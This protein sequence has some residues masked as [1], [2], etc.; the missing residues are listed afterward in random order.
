MHISTAC[1]PA[2]LGQKIVVIVGS[3][4]IGLETP[5]RARSEGADLILT[6]RDP[7]RLERAASE[8]GALRTAA[9]DANDPT[10]VERC[11]GKVPAPLDHVMVTG[12][13]PPYWPLMEAEWEQA[14]LAI[15]AHL[16]LAL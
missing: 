7:E 5:R 15:S 16:L 11:F 9:F 4:G 13:G 3:A 14:R 2:L 12:P 10:S 1:Q 8:F 6:A